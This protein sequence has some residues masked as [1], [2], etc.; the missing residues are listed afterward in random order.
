MVPAGNVNPTGTFGLPKEARVAYRELQDAF[1]PSAVTS[2]RG[3]SP[4]SS[5]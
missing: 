2:G 3:S 4:Q 1:G 5:S